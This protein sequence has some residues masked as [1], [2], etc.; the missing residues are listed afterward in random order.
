MSFLGALCWWINKSDCNP[1]SSN[2]SL[3]KIRGSGISF[4]GHASQPS[5][6]AGIFQEAYLRFCD[7][8]HPLGY[9]SQIGNAL[10]FSENICSTVATTGMLYPNGSS[11]CYD[12]CHLYCQSDT[13]RPSWICLGCERSCWSTL[14]QSTT[15]L[16]VH[17]P[18]KH[19]HRHRY[20]RPTR[21]SHLQD[22]V[23]LER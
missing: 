21:S 2:S 4:W 8:L 1:F 14:F 5:Y 23:V 13:M 20:P 9:V 10:F 7:H 3:C 16:V 11:C 17:I 15:V 6:E 22:S 19:Y 12:S 18:T